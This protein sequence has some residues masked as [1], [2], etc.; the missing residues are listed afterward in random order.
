[1]DFPLI[2]FIV[3]I[4]NVEL[5][6]NECLESIYK[7]NF[8]PFEVILIDDGSTDK[9]SQIAASYY[10]KYSNYT[11]LIKQEN[12]GLSAARNAGLNVARGDWIYFLDSD[13]FIDPCAFERVVN[14]AHG[15]SSDII[16]FNGF[17]HSDTDKTNTS[18]YPQKNQFV[19]QQ[20]V[21][22]Q[23]Y[24]STLLRS[25]NRLCVVVWD[26][27]YRRKSLEMTG[28]KFLNGV[29]HEDIHFTISLFVSSVSV[30]Y[31]NEKVV[32]YRQRVGSIMTL[33]ANKKLKS[34]ILVIDSLVDY[35]NQARINNIDINDYIVFLLKGIVNMRI[36]CSLALFRK[37]SGL[38]LSYKKRIVLI[39]CLLKNIKNYVLP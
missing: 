7:I 6:L 36:V 25:N 35:L 26:K 4:Y 29:V 11:T 20:K 34:K 18:L 38:K 10:E 30:Q 37:I 17:I 14:Y 9:S 23:K 31:I 16:T 8:E 27:I 1:M 19:N 24:I 15:C 3:P 32:F 28:L 39:V 12:G 33:D 5:Y 21:D 22:G 2:S 13:D